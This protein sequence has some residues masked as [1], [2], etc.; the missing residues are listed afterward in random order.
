MTQC[1]NKS[2]SEQLSFGT[3]FGKPVQA[4]F[5]GGHITSDAGIVLFEQVNK[6][7][8]IASF[9]AQK[10]HDPREQAKVTHTTEQLLTQRLMGLLAGYEDLNDHNHIRDDKLFQLICRNDGKPLAARDSMQ[11]LEQRFTDQDL[12]KLHE[13]YL[14]TFI[15]A[16]RKPP[17]QIILDMDNSDNPLHGHQEGRFFH[18]YYGHYCYLPLF[19]FCGEFPLVT[20]LRTAG[21]GL[22]RHNKSVIKLLVTGI[23]KHWPKTEIV[24]RGDSGF[25][26]W[27]M[28]RW[29]EKNNV[30][31]IFGLQKNAVLQRKTEQAQQQAQARAIQSGK[32]ERVFTEITYSAKSWD[33]DRRIIG[34]AEYLPGTTLTQDG[35]ANNR[36]IATNLKGNG[37]RLYEKVYCARGEAENRI[38]EYQGDLFGDRMSSSKLMAN[39]FRLL[40]SGF[41]YL[42][43]VLLR[44]KLTGTVYEK[45]QGE[46]LRLKLIKLGAR[47][48]VSARRIYLQLNEGCAVK[49][50][51]RHLSG[52]W[53]PGVKVS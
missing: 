4:D 37:K 25:C 38:K 19:V 2:N 48:R 20:L 5:T 50:I 10:L 8:G 31:Y 27:K 40:L 22:E 15:A 6:Q 9:I 29:C 43:T 28:M 49:E 3:L 7:Y 30:K 36:Y 32:A 44:M 33:K 11:R 21:K 41:A 51:L 53:P 17:R 34:K 47:I 24:I 18:G 13:V 35:K 12:I 39:Q 23:R 26:R 1:N 52:Q 45:A 42:I 14:K 46:R 16:H